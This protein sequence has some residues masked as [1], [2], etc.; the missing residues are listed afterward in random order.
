[1]SKSS[2]CDY[3]SRQ[4]YSGLKQL[5]RPLAADK[6]NQKK[7]TDIQTKVSITLGACLQGVRLLNTTQPL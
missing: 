7:L 4:Y 3:W 6:L 5:G 2:P 1:M